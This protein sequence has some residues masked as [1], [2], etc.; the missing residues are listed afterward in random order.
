[1]NTQPKTTRNLS[2]KLVAGLLMA[3]QVFAALPAQAAQ[4]QQ[5]G[6][7]TVDENVVSAIS[8]LYANHSVT[9][10]AQ[11]TQLFKDVAPN[12]R[13]ARTFSHTTCLPAPAY[14]ENFAPSSGADLKSWP[15]PGQ[16]GCT[17]TERTDQM[18][19]YVDPRVCDSNTIR[20]GYWLYFKKDGFSMLGAGKGHRHDWEGVVVELKRAGGNTWVRNQVIGSYHKGYR[21]KVWTDSDLQKTDDGLHPV[22]FVGWSHHAM[23]WDKGG[24]PAPVIDD[25][26]DLRNSYLKLDSWNNLVVIPVQPDAA[27]KVLADPTYFGRANPPLTKNICIV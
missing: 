27:Q 17:L 26:V 8:Q 21:S 10:Q 25:L 4:P 24:Q 6:P 7:I 18:V 11:W 2:F 3:T 23:H 13:F 15:V 16:A 19:T 22:M 1:M 12:F 9:Y 5:L 20:I 14:D